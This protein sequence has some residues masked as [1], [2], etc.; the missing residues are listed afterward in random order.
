MKNVA[1]LD[2][3]RAGMTYSCPPTMTLLYTSRGHRALQ[4]KS[5]DM[6]DAV[7]IRLPPHSSEQMYPILLLQRRD[8]LCAFFL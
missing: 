5:N 8:L 4:V 3:S 7:G 2:S 1:C 6:V